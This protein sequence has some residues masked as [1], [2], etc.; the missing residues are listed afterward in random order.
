MP[1][2]P[3]HAV[4]DPVKAP[5]QGPTDAGGGGRVMSAGCPESIR[6]MSGAGPLAPI[7]H[8]V[9]QSL[10]PM[11]VTRYLPRAA[12]LVPADFAAAFFAGAA[13]AV[14]PVD[15]AISP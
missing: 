2:G 3:A 4:M 8:G 7:V 15:T 10:Q 13:C 6:V 9:W 14:V 12:A 11:A 1:H 5:T